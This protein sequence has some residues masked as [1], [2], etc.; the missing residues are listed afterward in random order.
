MQSI[1][2]MFLYANKTPEKVIET[3]A[4]TGVSIA[5]NSIHTGIESLS[6]KAMEILCE[7]G[8]TLAM[9][10]LL[11]ENKMTNRDRF[12]AWKF[13]DDLCRHGPSWFARYRTHLEPPED[14]IALPVMKTTTIPLKSMDANNSRVGG[15]IEAIEGMMKQAGVG[16]RAISGN[17][18]LAELQDNVIL[19]HGDLGTAEKVDILQDRR[20]TE[21]S[22]LQRFQFVIF[23]M[24]LFH[25]KMT[26]ADALWRI[27][28]KGTQPNGDLTDLRQDVGVLRPHETVVIATSDE[29]WFPANA[30]ACI[31][32]WILS[33]P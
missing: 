11:N 20:K 14:I 5:V 13:L 22:P 23:V 17:P 27:F 6:D 2:G 16:D 29:A 21:A 32:R 26:C 18:N 12:N 3:L 10:R 15:N 9:L 25:L 30:R 31:A 19:V 7:R 28:L 1:Y 33:P 4:K 8:Q 24:G